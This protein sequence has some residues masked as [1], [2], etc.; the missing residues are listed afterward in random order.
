MSE[1]PLYRG[2]SF[3]RNSAPLG[4]YSR[5]LPSEILPTIVGDISCKENKPSDVA[6]LEKSAREGGG[7]RFWGGRPVYRGTSPM[8]KRPPP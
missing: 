6:S 8:G 4:P 7:V 5:S 1:V 2:N 3:M